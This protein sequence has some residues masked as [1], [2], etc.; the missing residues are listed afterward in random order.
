[1]ERGVEITENPVDP[2]YDLSGMPDNGSMISQ[3]FFFCPDRNAG[4]NPFLYPM[5]F[6]PDLPVPAPEQSGWQRR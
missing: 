5:K 4:I 1:M 3:F 6:S 2:I